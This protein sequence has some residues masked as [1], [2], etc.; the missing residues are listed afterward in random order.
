MGYKTHLKI[1]NLSNYL[2]LRIYMLNEW[3]AATQARKP[4]NGCVK[5]CSN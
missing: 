5:R 3:A 4:M 1:I 2:T